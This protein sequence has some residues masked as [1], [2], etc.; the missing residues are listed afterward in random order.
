MR[1]SF[2]M[3]ILFIRKVRYMKY[4]LHS[5]VSIAELIYCGPFECEWLNGYTSSPRQYASIAAS[6]IC[7]RFVINEG[8]KKIWYCACANDGNAG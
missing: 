4:A 6:S 5:A 2:I 7:N 8:E 1:Y 3:Q